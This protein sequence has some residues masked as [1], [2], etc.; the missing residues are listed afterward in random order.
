MHNKYKFKITF[1]TQLFWLKRAPLKGNSLYKIMGGDFF[2]NFWKGGDFENK[3]G[4]PCFKVF[5]Y[6]LL[7]NTIVK[8]IIKRQIISKEKGSDS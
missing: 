8:K 7:T 1:L 3:F 6:K 4:K 5:V 2:S